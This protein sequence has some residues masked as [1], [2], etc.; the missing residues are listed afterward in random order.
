MLILH[1]LAP[2]D[3]MEIWIPGVEQRIEV[4]ISREGTPEIFCTPETSVFRR[5]AAVFRWRAEDASG[6]KADFSVLQK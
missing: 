5:S 2:G 3:E 1:T 6:R 4:R